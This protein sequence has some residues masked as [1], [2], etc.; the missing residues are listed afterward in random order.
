MQFSISLGSKIRVLAEVLIVFTIVLGTGK[1]LYEARQ[2]AFISRYLFILIPV[3]FVYVPTV[4]ISIGK[5]QIE[6][7]G[8]TIRRWW[9]GVGYTLLLGAVTFP[10]FFL[11]YWLYRSLGFTLGLG[12]GGAPPEGWMA[13]AVYQVFF[14]ALPEEYFYRGYV[15]SRL[16]QAFPRGFRVLK[17]DFGWALIVAALLF[18]LGHFIISLQWWQMNVLFPGLLF[19]WLRERS[20]SIIAPTLFHGLCNIYIIALRAIFA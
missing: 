7:Y 20:G 4:I 3:L 11:G 9:G 12:T 6:D 5:R 15:Q 17:V 10:P 19:G 2:S 16:N 1:A 13:L 8:I 14:I 18:A